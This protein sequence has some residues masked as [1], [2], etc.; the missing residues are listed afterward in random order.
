M[1]KLHNPI[2]DTV[3]VTGASSGIGKALVR[4]ISVKSSCLILTGRNHTE[5]KQLAKELPCKT[6]VVQ[7]DL[8][9]SNDILKL[10]NQIKKYKPT[11]VFNN[12]GVGYYGELTT[13]TT[14]E[15]NDMVQLNFSA[16]VEISQHVGLLWKS[17]K[18]PGRL[19]NISSIAGNMHLP[20][21]AVY[22]ATKAAVTTF[23]I[24]L[25]EEWSKWGGHVMCSLPGPVK[26]QFQK[27][28]SRGKVDKTTAWYAITPEQCASEI[29]RALEKGKIK[30]ITGFWIRMYNILS[31]LTPGWIKRFLNETKPNPSQ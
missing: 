26:T 20:G 29:I 8:T 10:T 12:A 13:L 14:K 6:H 22:S 25:N 19:V 1:R 18:I 4:Q 9:C 27:T 16:L 30:H 3:L 17:K 15:I 2:Y 28:A 24:T 23:S 5:L 7:C 11:C 21:F 31:S